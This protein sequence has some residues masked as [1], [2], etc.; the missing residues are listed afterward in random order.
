LKLK[1]YLDKLVSSLRLEFKNVGKLIGIGIIIPLCSVL[2]TL[3]F[4]FRRRVS[5]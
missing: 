1:H 3:I 4:F 2:Y 5:N